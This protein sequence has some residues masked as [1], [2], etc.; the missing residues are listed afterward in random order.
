MKNGGY[1]LLGDPEKG[2]E[3]VAREG[4]RQEVGPDA[5]Q[6][7]KDRNVYRAILDG[8]GERWDLPLIEAVEPGAAQEWL[9]EGKIPKGMVTVLEGDPGVGKS[10]HGV[11]GWDAAIGE[12]RGDSASRSAGAGADG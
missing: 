4:A 8:G 7:T 3:I 11:A 10:L 9:W 5:E 6:V 12:S 2:A 1:V